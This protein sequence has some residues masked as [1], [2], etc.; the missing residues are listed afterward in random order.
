MRKQ[1]I[2]SAIKQKNYERELLLCKKAGGDVEKYRRLSFNVLQL[3]QIRR[4]L[5]SKI[6]V[7]AYLDPEMSW[8]EMEEIRTSLESGF[9]TKSY[10][11]RGFSWLQCKEI[12]AGLQAGVKVSV[13]E[14][15]SLLAPQ[16][17]EIRK[18]L[19]LGIDVSSYAS[20]KFDWF[21]MKEIRKGLMEKLN[22]S[23]YAKPEYKHDVMHAIRKGLMDKINLVPFVEEK[24]YSSKMLTEIHRG[25]MMNND[26]SAYLEQGY[27]AE[28]IEQINN[29][30]QAGVN[31]MPYL[32]IEFIGVQLREI[33]FGLQAGIDVS[34]Y[35]KKEYNWFQMREIRLGLE[36]GCDVSLYTTPDF[37]AQ[38]M[39]VIR[40]GL[41]EGLDVSQYAKVY[42]DPEEMEEIR[43][44][45][46]EE[47]VILSDEI[48]KMMHEMQAEAGSIEE[49][50]AAGEQGD[51][52]DESDDFVLDS[53]IIISPDNM[54]VT[55]DFSRVSDV[56]E[57]DLERMQVPDV[58]RLLAHHDIKQGISRA[59]IKEVLDN[60]M[61]DKSVVVAEG[62]PAKDGDDGYYTY[63]FRKK[64]NRKPRV[65]ENGSVDYKNIEL[66]EAVEKDKL[67]A[68]YH[69][70][71]PGSF[72]Y[73]VKGQLISPKKGKE[74]PPLHGQGFMVS[75]DKK[76][77]Y[78]LL[79]GIV[80]L[81]EEDRNLQVR[82][83]YTVV[84]NVD[85]S[86][87]NIDF[88]GD[89]NIMGN[90]EAGFSVTA[91]G[92]IVIDGFCEGCHISA[93]KDVII[94]KGCQ[95]QNTGEI[96]AGGEI[97]GQFFESV[98]LVSKGDVEA[99]Y[100]LNCQ[101]RTEGHL[102]V[103]GR[104]G[105][106]IGGN[107]RAKNGVTCH[108]IGN[109]AEV[110]TILEVGIDKE[111]MAA[112][113]EIGKKIDKVEAEMQTCETALHKF[114]EIPGRD[115]KTSALVERLTK[116][117]YSQKLQK[118][119]LMK[120]REKQMEKMSSHQEARIIVTGITF[121]GTTIF[122]NSEPY[123]VKEKLKNIEFVKK[124]RNI[125]PVVH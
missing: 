73:D 48:E 6:D 15:R 22:V 72:G 54:Q 83:L 92:N 104:K 4:G 19:Q 18:G 106:I 11:E 102:L 16:M 96:V 109:I 89:I 82:N 77:Y 114:M 44:R 63:Y 43:Q 115:E 57:D 33:I 62:K 13:Y 116:A 37:S 25:L 61:F 23:C 79:D 68:E 117:V 3:E 111:D 49:G 85:S 66:F 1:E 29:A 21:Q 14:N 20:P 78:S 100:L 36:Q 119:D 88:N 27:R 103:E 26:V 59:R 94:R 24:G 67:I 122:I 105:V 58:M 34:L 91:V 74:L 95:G 51:E 65:L 108:G 123:A 10:M 112:Y 5:E 39:Q 113:Q 2:D 53:C 56:M 42:F 93:G 75:E 121:P 97:K 110:K 101:L 120:E 40:E 41:Q 60:K 118:K 99:S 35:A 47:G 98:K 87:G 64:L 46:R 31:L 81:D 45:I 8:V 107:I 70:A 124:D 69:P 32:K 30:Y 86:T 125:G 50:E 90:V 12:R 71:T 38:Q 17:K 55:V 80:E 84:G 52:E 9:D 7:S 76:K 28:Q